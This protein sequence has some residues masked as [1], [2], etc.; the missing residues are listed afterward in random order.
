MLAAMTVPQMVL[1]ESEAKAL[2]IA[3]ANVQQH[4]PSI[5]LLNEKHTAIA[6]LIIVSGRIYGKRLMTLNIKQKPQAA[7][8]VNGQPPQ[9]QPMPASAAE[10]VEAWAWQSPPPPDSK[11]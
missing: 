9:V 11:H 4:Y 6:G 7:K 2:A 1:E 10:E 5:K 8:P 3:L